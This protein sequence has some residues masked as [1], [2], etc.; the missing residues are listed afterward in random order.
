[1]TAWP[2]KAEYTVN[3]VT[4]PIEVVNTI[5]SRFPQKSVPGRKSATFELP[6]DLHPAL[7]GQYF[8]LFLGA[9]STTG[10]LDS[11]YTHT[12]QLRTT[13]ETVG[14]PFTVHQA[15]G[16]DLA[17]IFTGNQIREFKISSDS[18]GLINVALT[19]VANSASSTDVA[20]ASTLTY[21]SINAL[22]FANVRVFITPS[23]G[24]E[25]ELLCDS[26]ELT[27]S[28]G[29][30]EARF[31][32]GSDKTR[33]LLINGGPM[34]TLK[35]TADAEKVLKDNADIYKDYAVRILITSTVYAAGTT[36]F[37]LEITLPKLM[38]NPETQT[39][40]AA[41]TLKMDLEFLLHTG[42]TTTNSGA[43]LTGAEIQVVDATT[44]W[45]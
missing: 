19:G 9:P 8:Q 4:Q 29:I 1:M 23:G 12:W 39:K 10:P 3:E 31:K 34:A 7:M 26:L 16:A 14:M 5:A 37:K 27:L 13:G 40:N 2:V 45:A 32:V 25:S 11:T 6:I 36:P 28:V 20:R 30:D 15:Y 17:T 41:E 42:G 18:E 21:P 38:L 24:S 33:Q 43:P 22:T 44:S 35:L